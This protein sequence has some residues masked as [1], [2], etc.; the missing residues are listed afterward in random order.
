MSYKKI[1]IRNKSHLS[2]QNNSLKIKN[3]STEAVICFDDIDTLIIETQQATLTSAL[4]AELSKSNIN[5][6]FSDK[7]FMPTSIMLGINKNS[8]TTKIQKAQIN[9]REVQ[10]KNIWKDIIIQKVKNQSY[11]LKKCN[12]KYEYLDSLIKRIKVGDKENIEATASAYYFKELFGKNFTRKNDCNINASLNYGYTVFRT[13]ICRYLIAYGLNPVFG[14][15]HCS[16]LNSFNLADDI[17]E[18][19]RPIIDLYTYKNIKKD[20]EFNKYIR[21]D[22]I[23]L[24]ETIVEYK[25]KKTEVNEAFKKIIANYQSICLSKTT[26]LELIELL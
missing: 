8:R 17:I 2:Y 7:N 23:S 1:Y 24:L 5:V 13:S 6:L 10:L 19:F 15:H 20:D 18:I 4:L 22:L 9:M 11:V 25:N 26:K 16:E 21:N 14:I 12:K 3:E